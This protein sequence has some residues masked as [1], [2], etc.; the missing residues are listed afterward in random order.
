MACCQQIFN[1]DCWMAGESD[2][3]F[4]LTTGKGLL[5][6]GIAQPTLPAAGLIDLGKARSYPVGLLVFAGR[7][8]NTPCNL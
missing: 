4:S 8:K 3:G 1:A 6:P 7:L 5:N 2:G